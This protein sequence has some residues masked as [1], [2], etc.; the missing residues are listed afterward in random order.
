MLSRIFLR[1]AIAASSSPN[2]L[3]LAVAAWSS[4]ATGP[5]SKGEPSLAIG[6]G[7][8]WDG[9]GLP[10]GVGP[11]AVTA[12]LMCRRFGDSLRQVTAPLHM[13]RSEEGSKFRSPRSHEGVGDGAQPCLGKT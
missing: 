2:A 11:P 1:A 9:L 4:L 3:S 5:E 12:L 6:R 7:T 10:S 13:P 8:V